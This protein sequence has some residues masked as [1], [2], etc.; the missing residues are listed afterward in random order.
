MVVWCIAAKNRATLAA[1]ATEL[2]RSKRTVLRSQMGR[3]SR[4][5]IGNETTPITA[6]RIRVVTLEGRSV[7]RR[8]RLQVP[9]DAAASVTITRPAY[10]LA[11]L[12]GPPGVAPGTIA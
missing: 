5:D 4:S 1:S 2:T 11:L 3:A 9:H 10:K 6:N 12:C 7:G 8:N